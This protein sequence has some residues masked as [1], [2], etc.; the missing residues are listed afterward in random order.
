MDERRT[1]AG[2]LVTVWVSVQGQFVIV[3]VV[4]YDPQLAMTSGF[5]LHV[6]LT[7]VTV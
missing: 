7:S 6:D 1:H 3:R 5:L 2:V 4:A